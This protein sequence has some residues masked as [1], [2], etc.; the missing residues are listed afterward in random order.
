MEVNPQNGI[1][2]EADIQNG[3]AME[4]EWNWKFRMELQC[5]VEGSGESSYLGIGYS[6]YK[7]N[8][9]CTVVTGASLIWPHQNC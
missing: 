7:I 6:D 4:L 5:G 2:I 9:Y 8:H 3:N 1:R